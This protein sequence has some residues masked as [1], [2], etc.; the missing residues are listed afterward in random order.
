[1]PV[2]ATEFDFGE[3]YL[4]NTLHNANKEN[5]IDDKAL[6]VNDYFLNINF[7]VKNVSKN[8]YYGCTFL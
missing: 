4:N 3:A 5:D 2:Q 7:R 6:K 1:M 8:K